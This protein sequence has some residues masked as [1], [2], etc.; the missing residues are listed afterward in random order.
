MENEDYTGVTIFF[1]EGE[2]GKALPYFTERECGALFPLR[3]VEYGGIYTPPQIIYSGGGALY[4][5]YWA[6]APYPHHLQGGTLPRFS[7]HMPFFAVLRLGKF[8]SKSNV[9]I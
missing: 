6:G 7:N 5:F 3:G 4:L 9:T 2:G 8:K 1:I